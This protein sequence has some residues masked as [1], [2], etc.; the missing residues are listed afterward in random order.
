MVNVRSSHSQMFF[1]I[2]ILNKF[3]IL[4]GKNYIY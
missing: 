2:D 4:T 3:E 1:E